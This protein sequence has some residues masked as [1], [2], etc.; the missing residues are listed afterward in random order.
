[1]QRLQS[2]AAA[3]HRRHKKQETAPAVVMVVGMPGVG[4]STLANK[5]LHHPSIDPFEEG[6]KEFGAESETQR[7]EWDGTVVIDTPA[8][9]SQDPQTTLTNFD[10]VVNALRREG[11]LSTLIFL[12][13]Q[14][15]VSPAEF[16]VYGILLRQLN[17][18]PCSKLIVC[19]QAALSRR[20]KRTE[21]DRRCDHLL[22]QFIS[23]K[24]NHL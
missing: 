24:L 16:A 23:N 2:A 14:E 17:R 20:H 8:I 9:P 3:T 5:L 15:E 4:R 10:V 12:V 7:A 18:L 13:Q 21:E 6:Y 11:S 19:R 1:M 22:R